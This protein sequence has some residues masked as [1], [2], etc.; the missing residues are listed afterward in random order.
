MGTIAAA[1]LSA[2]VG[3][4]S[5]AGAR[6][7]RPVAVIGHRG[8]AALAPENTLSA[9]ERAIA[10]GADWIEID[11]QET[12]D[13]EVVVLH[14]S[15]FK[16]LAGSPLKIWEGSFA[17][18]R[19][20]DVGSWFGPEFRGENVP[21]LEEV[22]L[23]ARGRA[24]VLIELKS[25]GRG[26]RLE[27]RVAEI[28]ERSGMER[29]IAV[30]SLER[31]AVE[32]MKALRPDFRRGLVAATAVGRLASV[33]VDFLAVS[34]PLATPSL[35]RQ[36]HA[37]NREVYVWTVNDELAMAHQILRG[38]DGLITDYPA[39]AEAAIRAE[40]ELDPIERLLVGTAFLLG[41]RPTRFRLTRDSD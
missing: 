33:D 27:E 1:V 25:Y 26:Q 5:L 4:L 24:K 40:S 34:V 13:G 36:A 15:D 35:I 10:A 11:V 2:I 8:A 14:D 16:K 28:V 22:L 39:R 31:R 6:D 38:V 12:A 20:L 18:I 30:M 37:R 3:W 7:A 9:V 29:E 19:K 32:K 41:A 21:T 17:E 23:R